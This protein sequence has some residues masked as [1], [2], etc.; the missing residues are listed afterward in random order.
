MIRCVSCDIHAFYMVRYPYSHCLIHSNF[1]RMLL[2]GVA[3][4]CWLV[5]RC[6]FLCYPW[7]VFLVWVKLGGE[8]M[9]YC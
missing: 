6:V 9:A 3:W 5:V 4:V 8:Q 1:S 7:L 2:G